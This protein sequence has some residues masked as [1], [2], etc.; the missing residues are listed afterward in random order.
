MTDNSTQSETIETKTVLKAIVNIPGLLWLDLDDPM[1]HELDD[2][3]ARH[4]FHELA[5]EDCRHHLQLAK[6][7]YYDGYTFIIINST[8]YTD[9]PCE[10]KVREI[11]AFLGPDYIVTVHEGPSQAVEEI[12]KRI[13]SSA[14]HITRPDQVL[15]ALIDIVVDRYL[16]TLDQIG[17]TIDEVEDELLINPTATLLQKIFELKRGLLGFRRAV[18]SQRELL[19]MLIR[20]DSPLVQ[21]DLRIYFRDVYDHAVRAMDLVETYRDLLTG[22]LDIYLTQMAN[23]TNDIVKA[24]TIL[25]TIML[26]LTL[27]TGY[28]GMNFEWMPLL[29]DP[30]GVWLTTAVMLIIVATM[31]GFFKRK[32]WL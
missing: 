24:L 7:D 5:V 25:A 31:L 4:G 1:S 10:V 13:A 11:D 30:R 16:P 17:D 2:L 26:P 28:F 3:A 21:E 22:G 32:K 20:D 27:V 12:Q 6:I 15:H 8:H 14:K 19:N 29:K 23:R 9:K 18:S